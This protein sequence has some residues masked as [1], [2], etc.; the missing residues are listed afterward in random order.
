MEKTVEKNKIKPLVSVGVP[1]HNEERFLRETLDSLLAQDYGNIEIIISDNAST[2]ETGEICIEY[3]RSYPHIRYFRFETNKG[4]ARNFEKVL[5]E[6]NGEFLMFG[7]GHDLW[8][9]NFISACLKKLVLHKGAA[10]AVPACKWIDENGKRIDKESGFSDTRGM[11][12]IARYFTIFWGNMHPAYGLIYA[13]LIKT[14]PIH[15]IIGEDLVFLT[16]LAL[17][18]DFVHAGE[19]TWSRREFRFEKSYTERL[20]RY[21]KGDQKVAL[22]KMDKLFPFLKLSYYLFCTVFQSKVPFFSRTLISIL[23]F[24]SIIIKYFSGK[25][26]YKVV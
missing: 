20:K 17:N 9:P 15:G 13:D 10:V 2:D 5:A 8:S 18:G 25:A 21:R 19:A 23:L 26:Q 11:D 1:V 4:Q 3:S 12:V 6:S 22:T 24:P 7:C 16:F 14:W